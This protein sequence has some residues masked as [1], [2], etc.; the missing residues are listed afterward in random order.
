M[1]KSIHSFLLICMFQIQRN[2]P[3][4]QHNSIFPFKA[5]DDEDTVT[6]E[7]FIVEENDNNDVVDTTEVLVI[8]Q[9]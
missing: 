3:K 7:D 8:C 6:V 4:A 5:A 2:N 1:K 9:F